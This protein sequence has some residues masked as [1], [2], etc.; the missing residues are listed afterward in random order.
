MQAVRPRF[1]HW[2]AVA[3]GCVVLAVAVAAIGP[4]PVGVFYDDGIYVILAKALATGEGYRYLNIPGMPAATH[5]PPGYP[6]FLALLLKLT[7]EFPRNA[8][9]LKLANAFLLG[10]ATTGIVALAR[11]RLKL[12]P[13]AAAGA[14]VAFTV[15]VPVL[16][17]STV[18]FSEPLFLAILVPAL[19]QSERLLDGDEHPHAA[20]VPGVLCGLATL[21]RTLGIAAIAGALVVLLLR[22]RR[23][24]AGMFA[25]A[26]AV[27][28]L[29]WLLWSAT[30]NSQVPGV[31]EWSYGSYV[32]LLV[33]ALHEVGWAFPFQVVARNLREMIRPLWGMFATALPAPVAALLLVPVLYTMILG[34]RRLR[35]H[36]PI[37]DATLAIYLAIVLLWPV[38]PDRFLWAIWPLVGVVLALGVV[39]LWSWR[40]HVVPVRGL[41]FATMAALVVSTGFYVRYNVRGIAG[42]WHE[43]A[44]RAAAE[45]ALPLARWVN[46]RTVRTDVVATDSDPLVYLYTGR[47]TVPTVSWRAAYYLRPQQPA[48]MIVNTRT[49]LE[50]F[51]VRFLLVS[52]PATPIG[53]ASQQLR[54][55]RPPVLRP[56]DTL[57]GGGLVYTRTRR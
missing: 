38:V 23:R 7:P 55:A 30:Y 12:P 11:G 43:S 44:Q 34:L 33:D 19:V 8:I 37:I 40:P 25:A 6:L 4:Y 46:E 35:R 26:A 39:E 24:A 15:A 36:A 1:G 53:A 48:E 13:L 17:M 49:L 27:V 9:V 45:K 28:L 16:T 41:R 5:Y 42:R 57:S 56:V 3:A 50:T 2:W 14:V 20:V 21:V 52:S 31:L 29:P 47:R 22:G 32:G 54:L 10:I 18:L 51:D